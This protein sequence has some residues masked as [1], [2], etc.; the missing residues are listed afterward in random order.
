MSRQFQTCSYC[1]TAHMGYLSVWILP[2]SDLFYSKIV[3][4]CVT[5]QLRKIG[6]KIQ[7]SMI[8]LKKGGTLWRS[9]HSSSLT[10]VLFPSGSCSRKAEI[11]F[12]CR[13][14][15]LGHCKGR[16]ASGFSPSRCCFPEHRLFPGSN[17]K[18]QKPAEQE[19]PSL[20]AA[21]LN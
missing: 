3:Y 16:E 2:Y 7:T 1:R 20:I 4:S 11:W 10:L 13:W 15:F 12:V 17:N 14:W 6:I 8:D 21:L 9:L 19:I 5:K 18:Q